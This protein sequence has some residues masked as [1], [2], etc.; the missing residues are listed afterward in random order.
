MTQIKKGDLA[1]VRPCNSM[2]TVSYL[3]YSVRLQLH[4]IIAPATCR[5]SSVSEGHSLLSSQQCGDKGHVA[6]T[7]WAKPLLPSG[8]DFET[9]S[10][11]LKQEIWVSAEGKREIARY[12]MPLKLVTK[13]A[14][15]HICL[16]WVKQ[17]HGFIS[18]F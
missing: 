3:S 9:Q 15:P 14:F 6:A 8:F 13:V 4:I 5:C 18:L 11:I 1:D 2:S 12:V 17:G 16:G 7:S 10:V